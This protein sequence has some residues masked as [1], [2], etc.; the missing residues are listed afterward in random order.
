MNFTIVANNLVVSI[1]FQLR[2]LLRKLGFESIIVNT[3]EKIDPSTIYFIIY[4]KGNIPPNSIYFQIEQTQSNHFHFEQLK[5]ANRV[6]DFSFSNYKKYKHLNIF[7]KTFYLPMPF[8]FDKN[9]EFEPEYDIFFYGTKN[10]RREKIMNLLSQKYNVKIGFSIS[11]DERDSLIQKSKI[12]INLHYYED[13]CLE[14]CRFNEILQF[15]KLILSEKPDVNDSWNQ[16]LYND[17]VV[18]FEK[19]NIEQ[20]CK[21]IDHYLDPAIYKNKT[22]YIKQNK[23]KLM[24]HCTYFLKR[25]LL[26]VETAPLRYDLTDKIYCL[27]LPETPHRYDAFIQQ[28]LPLLEYYPGIKY[29]PGWKGCG[30]SYKNII[31]NAKR[32]GLKQITICEDDCCFKDDFKEKYAVIQ[33]FLT[34]IS[35]D[36]FVGVLA[37]L[38]E[39][40]IL[41]NVY[42]YKGMTFLE[43]NKMHSMVF[44]IY[45]YTCYD[46]I[47]NCPLDSANNQIDQF[48]KKQNFTIIIP[49]P[50][51]FSC[52]NVP[53]TIWDKNLFHEYNNMFELSNKIILKK[54]KEYK[55]KT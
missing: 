33:E 23:H 42:D 46:R 21:L 49:F 13:S 32:C 35:W 18:F 16:V 9:I 11:G 7:D 28:K 31:Y 22:E 54:L 55:A 1:A 43:L 37:D 19:D 53:S 29:S 47:L 4:Y 6:L 48:I 12:V 5:Q 44:N 15:N 26:S 14:T 10:K 24:K 39:D 20:L 8:Y 38:P 17:F 41:S 2:G 36:I 27:T 50:F 52:L 25:A 3:I 34:T 45:N 30:L 40:T 51:E